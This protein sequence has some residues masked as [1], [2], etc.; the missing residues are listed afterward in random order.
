VKFYQLGTN[1]WLIDS[2][3]NGYLETYTSGDSRELSWDDAGV[4]ELQNLYATLYYGCPERMSLNIGSS[5][6]QPLATRAIRHS[7]D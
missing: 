7:L 3:A 2:E 6:T 4:P 1:T 5:D